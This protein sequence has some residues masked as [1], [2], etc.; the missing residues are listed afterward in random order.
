GVKRI[1]WRR[2]VGMPVTYLA[3]V[4]HFVGDREQLRRYREAECPGSFH[5]DDQLEDGRL[6][7][8]QV[9]GLFT[10]QNTA[11]VDTGLAISVRDTRSIAH[12]ATGDRGCARFV[13]G[14]DRALRR[15]GHQEV[16]PAVQERAG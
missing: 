13:G 14:R 1:C 8:R 4:D 10:L 16:S 3:S 12:Q 11:D 15:S 2:F 7:D 9:G 6:E 5:I